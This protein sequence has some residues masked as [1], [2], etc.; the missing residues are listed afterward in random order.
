MARKYTISWS[1]TYVA[2]GTVEIKAD[3]HV[4]AM[5]QVADE[6]GDYE[7]STQYRPEEDTVELLAWFDDRPISKYLIEE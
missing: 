5:R 7:G 2:T 6:I 4:E 1:K 3:S